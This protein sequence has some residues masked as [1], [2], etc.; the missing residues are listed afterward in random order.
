M[1]SYTEE[2]NRT[3]AVSCAN[4]IH[5]YLMTE[6]VVGR[7]WVVEE[8]CDSGEVELTEALVHACKS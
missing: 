3:A 4:M 5:S 1:I 8:C 6:E 7:G 2:I